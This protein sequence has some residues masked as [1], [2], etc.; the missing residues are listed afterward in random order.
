MFVYIYLKICFRSGKDYTFNDKVFES[1]IN[2][3]IKETDEFYSKML[4]KEALR[5]GFFE[6]QATRD[7]YRELS[8]LDGMHVDLILR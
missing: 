5:T 6:L 2:L 3:K 7:K 4:F 8:L 1:E